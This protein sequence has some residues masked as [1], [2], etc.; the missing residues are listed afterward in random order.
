[1]SRADATQA[2]CA[3][4]RAA[5][6]AVHPFTKTRTGFALRWACLQAGRLLR[7]VAST[8]D[9]STMTC[10]WHEDSRRSDVALVCEAQGS[11]LP[12]VPPAPVTL[13]LRSRGSPSPHAPGLWGL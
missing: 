8:P 2:A 7:G 10:L 5:C 6:H 11:R 1:M 13:S 4:A 12:G 3:T 9:L